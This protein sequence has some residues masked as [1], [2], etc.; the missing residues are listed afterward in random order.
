[1]QESYILG[2]MNSF[3]RRLAERMSSWM[4]M[5]LPKLSDKWWDELVY[6]NL[7]SLQRSL[8]D[9]NNITELRGLDLASLLRVFDRNW[10]VLKDSWFM[11][12]KYRQQIRDMMRIRNDWAHLSTEELSKEKVVAD[13]GVIID[14]MSAF[15]AKPE[16]TREMVAFVLDVKSDKNIQ[17]NPSLSS[18]SDNMTKIKWNKS[19]DTKPQHDSL[20]LTFPGD[21]IADFSKYFEGKAVIEDSVFGKYSE[22]TDSVVKLLISGKQDDDPSHHVVPCDGF[23]YN[24][25]EEISESPIWVRIPGDNIEYWA[26]VTDPFDDVT[27]GSVNWTDAHK[28]IP[29]RDRL[30]LAAVDCKLFDSKKN[31]GI[32]YYKVG[33]FVVTQL[34]YQ[35]AGDHVD[36]DSTDG[37][38][39]YEIAIENGYFYNSKP[40]GKPYY[41]EFTGIVDYWAYIDEPYLN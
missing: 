13:V 20:V 25:V 21:N 15:D 39:E 2:K 8:V 27:V 34:Y 32:I 38:Y 35:E 10:F 18:K 7:S 29:Q 36:E 16:D 9:S 41:T 14:L 11:N 40:H 6:S 31:E 19:S 5:R 33:N 1:M 30:I 3:M 37:V 23:Y 28:T 26:Y 4:G 12:P 24:T 22:D 17:D